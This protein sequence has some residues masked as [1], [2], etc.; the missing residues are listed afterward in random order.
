ME[1]TA[2][3]TTMSTEL[4]KKQTEHDHRNKSNLGQ[5]LA[6]PSIILLSLPGTNI[7]NSFPLY[8]TLMR[9]NEEILSAT[10]H[11]ATTSKT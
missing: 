6:Y 9:M 11:G 3:N 5:K 8:K 7:F 10:K 4:V 2:H 1:N